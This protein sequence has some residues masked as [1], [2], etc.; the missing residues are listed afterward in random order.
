VSLATL[1]IL[2]DGSDFREESGNRGGVL[3]NVQISKELNRH[4]RC[5]IEFRQ[6]PDLRPPIE[7]WIGKPLEIHST[8]LGAKMFSGFIQ[9]VKLDYET[10]GSFKGTLQ[11]VSLSY[12]LDVSERRFYYGPVTIGDVANHMA[13]NAGI[14]I[15]VRSGA[16]TKPP[17]DLVQWSET[18]WNY[19][20]RLCDDFGLYLIATDDGVRI[21]KSFGDSGPELTWRS[22]QDTGI[23]EFSTGAGLAPASTDGCH[24][25]FSASKSE[26]H[27]KVSRDPAVSG[28][29][30]PLVRAAQTQSKSN[31]GPAYKSWRHRAK[32]LSDYHTSLQDEAEWSLGS[33]LSCEGVSRCEAL[34]PGQSVRVHG[35]LDAEGKYNIY[36][37]VHTWESSGYTN[38]FS[39]TPWNNYRSS[40]HPPRPEVSGAFSARVTDIDDPQ[41]QGQIR[42]QYYW[43]EQGQTCW[44]RHLTPYA[45]ANRGLFFRPEVG[46]EVLIAF[47]EGDPER[48]LILGSAWN[49]SDAIPNEDFW[50]AETHNNDVKRIVTKSGHRFSMVDKQG[51]EAIGLA[52]PTHTKIVLHEKAN[53]TGRPAILLNVEDGDI[54]LNAPNGRIHFHAKYWSREVGE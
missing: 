17:L 53:E 28:A 19:L 47:E 54:V 7:R 3:R 31:F 2:I 48:P 10:S 52:T 4:S 11:A 30:G 12:K 9:D 15:K 41:R 32:S 39:C 40:P 51:E 34:A 23:V 13:G 43:Q 20:W 6:T 45:G 18:D 49:M 16:G 22:D 50:G 26:T 27:Q 24:Y 29:I 37:V 38:R 1:Q 5:L 44:I 42:V 8:V 14:A 25:D 46:D 33:Q 21:D 35:V 36:R